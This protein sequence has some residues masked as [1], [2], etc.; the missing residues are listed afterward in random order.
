SARQLIKAVGFKGFLF[1]VIA[2]TVQKRL[3]KIVGVEPG[4]EMKFAMTLA[5]NNHL[6]LILIDKSLEKTVKR[7]FKK[8]TW[9][10]KF[11]FA[12]QI[13]AA[14]FSPKKKRMKVPLT[15]VPPQEMIEKLMGVLKKQFPTM[16]KVLVDE[17]NH[18]MARKAARY[19]KLN[20]EKKMMLIV[21]AGHKNE[22][23]RLIPEYQSRI[24]V[25]TK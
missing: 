24:E 5:K 8:L 7:L 18:Y 25:P 3:G 4:S 11:R 9:K 16:H 19:L 12:G 15:K 17:R 22:I 13:V 23:E 1:T 2:R 21:G 6:D 20:P 14:P 10:E